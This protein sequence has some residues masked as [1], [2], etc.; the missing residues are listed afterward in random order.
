MRAVWAA[1]AVALVA[2]GCGG[3]FD[4][5]AA[6]AEITQTWEAFFDGS[7]PLEE[8][9]AQLE[10]GEALREVLEASADDPFTQNVRARVTGVTFTDDRHATVT[11][12]IV[13]G[14]QVLLSGV[15]GEAV[16][17]ADRWLVGR[18]IFCDLQALANRF[19]PAG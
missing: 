5:E 13:A 18:R 11:F 2:V 6:R 12:D 9:V 15:E 1:V 14:D 10:D 19:C 4:E 8:K 17:P 7:R 16:R 3:G